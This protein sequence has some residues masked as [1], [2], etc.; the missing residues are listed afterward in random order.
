VCE[1]TTASNSNTDSYTVACNNCASSCVWSCDNIDR[2][3]GLFAV[4]DIM[5]RNC[6]R[7]R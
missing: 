3:G 2:A 4:I 5:Q 1:F 6:W 7:I